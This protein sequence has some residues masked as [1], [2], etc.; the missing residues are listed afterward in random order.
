M[1]SQGQAFCTKFEEAAKQFTTGPEREFAQKFA[2]SFLDSWSQ[3]LTNAKSAP[4]PTYS[5]IAASP[6]AASNALAHQPRHRQQDRQQHQPLHRQGQSTVGALLRE[7]FRVFIRLD[8]EAPAKTHKDY[9]IR[10]HISRK[11]GV[12]PRK[13]P[14]VLQ[15][16]SGW[17]VLAA[18]ITTRDLLM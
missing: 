8:A 18:D 9:A 10:T 7:D 6:P 12:D 1:L 3:A 16:R 15:V 13:I 5:S 4:A 14:R 11:L 17:A 2:H